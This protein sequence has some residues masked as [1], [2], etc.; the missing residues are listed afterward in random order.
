LNREGLDYFYKVI[1]GVEKVFRSNTD[2]ANIIVQNIERI[3]NRLV[4]NLGQDLKIKIM[5]FCGTHEWTVTHFGLRSLVPQ[6]IELI[7][8]PGCPVCV[9]PS[10]YIEEV[11][12]LALDGVV[13]YTYGDTYR[14][15]TIKP[16][17]GV[18]SLSEARSLGADVKV[19]TGLVE[20]IADSKKHGKDSIFI[21]I[22]FETI[23][24]GYAKA[25][26]SNAIPNN[27]KLMSLVKLTPPA[28]RYTLDIHR[29]ELPV[30]GVIAPGHVSTIVGAKA[31][32]QISEEFKIPIVISGFEPIDVMISILKILK[33]LSEGIYGTVIEYKRA[34]TWNGDEVAQKMINEIFDV[35]DD[36]W[37]GIGF[38]PKS[39]LRLKQKFKSSDAFEEFKIKELEKSDWI[40]DL[41][42]GCRCADIILGK[43]LPTN[44]PLFMKVCT[45]ST[46]VGPCM[47]SIEGTCSIWAKHGGKI[48]IEIAKD[49]SI[50]IG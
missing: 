22:G 50:N 36:A 17:K 4:E 31:W 34:V 47:V 39:G 35:V 33:Q 38:I 40:Y 49:L 5:N 13:V 46:P 1:E 6:N 16:V 29:Q 42:P 12:R 25:I 30:K 9:T 32:Q 24:S 10:Y 3:V 37:R 15:R 45:P 44:C 28:M 41:S 14:L 43:A 19:V 20:A 48:A 18:R 27:L 11:L 2:L 26:L 8:G 21:G 7:A 23:A